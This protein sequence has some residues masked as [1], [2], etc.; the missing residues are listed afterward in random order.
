[1]ARA[2]RATGIVILVVVLA[3]VGG[4]GALIFYVSGQIDKSFDAVR[5]IDIPV[6]LTPGNGGGGSGNGGNGTG[7]SSDKSKDYSSSRDLFQDMTAHGARCKGFDEVTAN[8][9]VSAGIC[10]NGT[11]T[12]TIQVYF[13]DSAY[14]A[15]LNGYLGS[16]ATQAAYGSNWIVLV[17]ER[18]SAKEIAKALNGRVT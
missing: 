3:V 2:G 18:K 15:V 4:V 9:V 13:T 10:F 11:E 1:M 17:Q 14:N 12:W 8:S 6:N 7:G 16:D 5:D